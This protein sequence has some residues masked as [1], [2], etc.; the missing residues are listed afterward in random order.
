MI[1]SEK[2]FISFFRFAPTGFFT[3]GFLAVLFSPAGEVIL[4]SGLTG[5]RLAASEILGA[6]AVLAL[7]NYA[8]AFFFASRTKFLTNLFLVANFLLALGALVAVA[9]RLYF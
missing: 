2:I 7:L 4:R 1:S 6:A 3:A 5:G 9:S 8:L